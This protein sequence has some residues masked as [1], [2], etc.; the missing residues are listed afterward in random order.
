M[1]W[2]S[3]RP[4]PLVNEKFLFWGSIARSNEYI[5]LNMLSADKSTFMCMIKT[6]DKDKMVHDKEFCW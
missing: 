6:F 4:P 1:L 2:F 3:A 5:W